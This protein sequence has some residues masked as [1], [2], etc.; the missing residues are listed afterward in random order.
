[1]LL[2]FTILKFFNENFFLQMREELSVNFSLVINDKK[3]NI[4]F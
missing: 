2:F 4:S 3:E 1:M